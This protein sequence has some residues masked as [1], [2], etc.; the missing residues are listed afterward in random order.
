MDV[1]LDN[2]G[3]EQLRC[4]VTAAREGARFVLVGALSGQLAPDGAGRTCPVELD[5][6]QLLLKKI[7]MRGYSADD[8][9]ATGHP[10]WLRRFG[11]WLRSGEMVFPLVRV[12]GL[13]RAVTALLEV[14]RGDHLGTVVVEL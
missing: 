11:G 1:F 2:A 13:E 14:I 7:T 10:E 8:D 12:Q 3:G 6:F 9:F 5:S 4:A